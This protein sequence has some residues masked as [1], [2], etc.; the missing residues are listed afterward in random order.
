MFLFIYRFLINFV[1]LISPLIIL[2]RLLK[3]KENFFRFKEKFNF[4]SKK[5]IKGK[6]VWFHGASVGEILSIIPLIEKLENDKLVKQILVTSSTVSSAKVMQKFYFKKTIH[7]FFP[8]DTNYISKNFLD[9]W[10]PSLALF[11]DS[12]IWPNMLINLK[13]KSIP[14]I[15]LNARITPKSFFRWKMFGNFSKKIFQCF[16][17]CLASNKETFQYLKYFKLKNIKLIGNLKFSEQERKKILVPKKI[18]NFF[19][20]KIFWCAG[21]THRGEELQCLNT[22]IELKKKIQKFSHYNY[23]KTHK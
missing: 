3:K 10:K 21:S 5:K 15:L 23:S 11:I 6:L 19:L 14:V 17:K 16:S 7:Q 18:K 9:Y 12:E 4:F 13:K 20:T 2:F 1:L 22:H 8:I